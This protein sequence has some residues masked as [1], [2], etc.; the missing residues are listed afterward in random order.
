[1]LDDKHFIS[2]YIQ[3]IVERAEKNGL[4]HSQLARKVF[5]TV[6]D[7]PSTW[8]KIRSGTQELKFCEAVLL[9]NEIGLDIASVSLE[10][11]ELMTLEVR[12]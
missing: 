11:R 7:P 5:L 3:F 6:K 2:R 9:A 10:V 12:S 8:R 4:N 1:M